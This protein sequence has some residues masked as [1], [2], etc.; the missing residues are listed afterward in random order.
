MKHRD[1][2][3]VVRRRV[4][5]RPDR[6]IRCIKGKARTTEE[7]LAAGRYGTTQHARNGNKLVDTEA[8][9]AA[10]LAAAPHL[11]TREVQLQDALG[12]L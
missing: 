7:D 11:E 2:W 1:L 4:N 12:S 10:T 5:S 9:D 3:A 6:R 8:G